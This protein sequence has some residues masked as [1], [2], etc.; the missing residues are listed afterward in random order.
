MSD[1]SVWPHAPPHFTEDFGVYMVTAS[2]CGKSPYL[3]SRKR[4]RYVHERLI[5]LA[6]H[7]GWTLQAWAVLSNHYHFVAV[8]PEEGAGSLSRFISHLHTDTARFLNELDG[9]LG[10]KVWQNY[11]DTQITHDTSHYARLKY[12]NENAVHHGLVNDATDYPWCSA[13]W[14]EKVSS[15][16]FYNVVN[17]FKTDRLNIKDDF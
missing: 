4:L 7:Y 5:S 9:E 13:R 12:V 6:N 16:S 17:S 8:S 14:F 3:G 11:W 2:T 15:V 1:Q 10:R